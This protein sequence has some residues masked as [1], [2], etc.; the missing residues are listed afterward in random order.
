MLSNTLRLNFCYLKMI[1]FFHTCY[2]QEIIGDILK[3]YKKQER[4]FKRGY[5]INDNEN[6]AKNEK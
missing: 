1:R 5:M 3:M 6:E 4:L 2:H